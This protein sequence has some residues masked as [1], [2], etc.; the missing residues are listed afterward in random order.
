M[1]QWSRKDVYA[2][3]GRAEQRRLTPSD[4]EN[5]DRLTD[6]DWTPLQLATLE[7]KERA[8]EALLE[9]KADVN[10]PDK[11]RAAAANSERLEAG[12]SQNGQLAYLDRL[13]AAGADVRQA[14]QVS[15]TMVFWDDARSAACE[16]G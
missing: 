16:E 2:L 11:V 3:L 1:A 8:V 14:T 12:Q 9:K 13:I 7:G 5:I 10:K 6:D 4:L 15:V